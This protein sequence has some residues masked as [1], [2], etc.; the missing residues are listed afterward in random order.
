M[1]KGYGSSRT[2]FR[3]VK[4]KDLE[5]SYTDEEGREDSRV[6]RQ[7]QVVVESDLQTM[8]G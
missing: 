5:R 6:S 4:V 3:T 2:R 8:E 1:T 7:D